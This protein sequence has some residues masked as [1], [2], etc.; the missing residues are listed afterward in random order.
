MMKKYQS[1]LDNFPGDLKIG[2]FDARE[3]AIILDNS[4]TMINGLFSQDKKED[5][6]RELLFGNLGDLYLTEK[7]NILGLM[8][9]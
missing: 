1:L 9:F 5:M 6:T 4:D 3:K 2:K 7:R 8:L